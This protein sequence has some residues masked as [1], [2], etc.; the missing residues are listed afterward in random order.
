M[1]QLSKMEGITASVGSILLAGSQRLSDMEGHRIN[2]WPRKANIG[3]SDD[4]SLF[5]VAFSQRLVLCRGLLI[6]P[7]HTHLKR[8]ESVEVQRTPRHFEDHIQAIHVLM[9]SSKGFAHVLCVCVF[10]SRLSLELSDGVPILWGD[11]QVNQDLQ[12]ES[13]TWSLGGSLANFFNRPT[14]CG[15]VKTLCAE[16]VENPSLCAEERLERARICLI[17]FERHILPLVW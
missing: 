2:R 14:W 1:N 8:L 11:S 5:F 3:S 10:N 4:G 7:S 17:W 15:A 6:P 9:W 16:D 12:G 13:E